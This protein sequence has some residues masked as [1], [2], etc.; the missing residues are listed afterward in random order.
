VRPVPGPSPGAAGP[1]TAAPGPGPGAATGP[2]PFAGVDAPDLVTVARVRDLVAEAISPIFALLG[3]KFADLGDARARD[4]SDARDVRDSRDS[5]GAFD[6][7]SGPDSESGS[8]ESG[9]SFTRDEFEDLVRE[10]GYAYRQT[11]NPHQHAKLRTTGDDPQPRLLDA[12]AIKAHAIFTDNGMRK[13]GTKANSLRQHESAANFAWDCNSLMLGSIRKLHDEGW[14]DSDVFHDLCQVYNSQHELYRLTNQERAVLEMEANAMHPNAPEGDRDRATFVA[15]SI[16]AGDHASLDA[17]V[18]VIRLGGDY[19]RA[20]Q[21]CRLNHAAKGSVAKSGPAGGGFSRNGSAKDAKKPKK[22]T[23]K[24]AGGGAQREQR[25]RGDRGKR[26][27]GGDERRHQ[28]ARGGG[29]DSDGSREGR[30]GRQRPRDDSRQRGRTPR[31][32]AGRPKGKESDQQQ[33]G[34]EAS[35]RGGSGGRGSGRG[36]RS[37][38]DRGK[39][40]ETS[41]RGQRDA[42]RDGAH[43]D[44]SSASWR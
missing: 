27:G 26:G 28:A 33:R 41:R 30:A 1:A 38:Y 25:E 39:H 21:R 29:H 16:R 4:L 43:S 34:K 3:Q 17:D 10:R 11:G 18:D 6:S 20:A 24:R 12:G 13:S 35:Q 23:D 19:D 31:R 40:G 8:V 32:D 9:Q 36:G 22:Q 14:E 5:H 15:Q 37:D 2:G 7:A 44:A 42:S